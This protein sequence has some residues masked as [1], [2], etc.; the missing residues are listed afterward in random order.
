MPDD[1]FHLYRRFLAGQAG[2]CIFTSTEGCRAFITEDEIDA[3]PGSRHDT[4]HF[5]WLD[6]NPGEVGPEGI[7]FISDDHIDVLLAKRR[8]AF[9]YSDAGGP[10]GDNR[11]GVRA[12]FLVGAAR[13]SRILGLPVDEQRRVLPDAI[14]TLPLVLRA[15]IKRLALLSPIPLARLIEK[16]MPLGAGIED[17]EA[18]GRLVAL[19]R[20]AAG[21][22]LNDIEDEA[23]RCAAWITD[24]ATRQATAD[25]I[26]NQKIARLVRDKG[27]L[28]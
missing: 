17:A 25:E 7:G 27:R 6:R 28:Q 11:E 1:A 12:T 24:R 2:V 14:D 10:A 22:G 26:V 19:A 5:V 16:M 8:I 15:H 9:S 13:M 20:I 4:R 23:E 18:R 21:E 3:G